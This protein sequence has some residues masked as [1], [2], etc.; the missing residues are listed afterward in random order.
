MAEVVCVASRQ[1]VRRPTGGHV[2]TRRT[3]GRNVTT[4]MHRRYVASGVDGRCGGRVVRG[5]ADVPQAGVEAV[6][7]ADVPAGL[8]GGVCARAD[9]DRLPVRGVHP[10][11]VRTGGG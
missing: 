11:M 9:Q 7:Q 4:G 2:V 5:P 1:I 6:A 3:R 10:R 8:F